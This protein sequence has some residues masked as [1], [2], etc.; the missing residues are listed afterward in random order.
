[1]NDC[2][3]SVISNRDLLRRQIELC[4]RDWRLAHGRFWMLQWENRVRRPS[5]RVEMEDEAWRKAREHVR[6]YA[7]LRRLLRSLP[8]DAREVPPWQ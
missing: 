8:E 3:T 7:M 5:W 6:R 4:R 2:T 1:M